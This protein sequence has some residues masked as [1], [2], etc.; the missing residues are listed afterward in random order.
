MSNNSFSIDLGE[1]N[2]RVVAADLSNNKINLVSMGQVETVPN[3]FSSESETTIEKQAETIY[4]LYSS[5]KIKEKNVHVII[6]DTFTYSQIT[7][8]PKLNE[9][10]LVSAIRYQADQFIPMPIDQTT[11]DI[12]ILKED[13]KN[14]KVTVL[15][16][17]SPKSLVD[18]VEKTIDVA[19]L[20]PQSLENELSAI[21]RLTSELIKLKTQNAFLVF[22][23]GFTSSSIYLID[24]Q[25]S[26]ILMSRVFKIGLD[27]FTK[28]LKVNLN[29]DDK[30]SLEIL[31]TI[32]LEKNA[33]YNIENLVSPIVKELIEE[34]NKFITL[35]RDQH[36][37]SIEKIFLFNH[38]ND[39]LSLDK[40]IESMTSIPT[41]SL[42]LI[43]NVVNNPIYQSFS[44]EIPS[45]ISAIAGNFR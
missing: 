12:E 45:F 31:K 24:G 8:M 17:A 16:I 38:S 19:G 15:I 33:S 3:Y 13:Q 23:F 39:I 40:K 34:F 10:E 29:Y 4:K 9:K 18:Q 14:K 6:P 41:Q 2:T 35:A 32:G 27:L 43:D 5:L 22:N 28:D 25:T 7:E 42:N 11:I 21:G 30:K 1:K 44:D 26:L 36:N 20:F 37:L